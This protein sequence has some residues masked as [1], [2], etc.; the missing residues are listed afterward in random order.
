MKKSKTKI[1]WISIA[2]G[3]LM[4]FTLMLLSSVINIGERLRKIHVSV[5]IAFYVL[6][7]LIVFLVIINP[8]RI[9]LT[10]PSFEICTTLD[11]DSHKVRSVYRA[12]ARNMA[13]NQNVDEEHR[14]L[15]TKYK[16]YDELQMNMTVVFHDCIKKNLNNIIIKKA[17]T[18]LISTA[19]CQ[20]ARMD[21]ITVFSVNLNMIKNLV[22]EC[23]FRPNM[24]N[25]SKLTINVFSTALIAEGL[26]S[27]SIDDI[28]PNSVNNALG[29]IP[30]IKPVMASVTQG[31]ANALLTIRIGCVTR[32]YLFRDG[33]IITK[34][35]IRK[36]AFK[37][38]LILLPMVLYGTLTFIPKKIVHMF[39]SKNKENKKSAPDE[40]LM[41]AD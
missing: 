1:F 22:I 20:N 3:C 2:I 14:L 8:I 30:F 4:V 7:F 36:S 35:D 12:V 31:I 32:K 40:T 39:G 37:D 27:I 11:P 24:T 25:L 26:E 15:L 17:K 9:I 38:S 10:S 13:K 19:I 16:N 41:I 18:V 6:V 34:E 23:G 21:M 29:Q 33:N 28:L 5:E